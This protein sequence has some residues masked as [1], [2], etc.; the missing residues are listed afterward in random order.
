[1]QVNEVKPDKS[2]LQASV[3]TVPV[4]Q[5][6]QTRLLAC[7][8]ADQ[9]HDLA[10]AD[11]DTGPAPAPPRRADNAPS[12]RCHNCKGAAARPPGPRTAT[13]GSPT[14]TTPAGPLPSA[15][16]ACVREDGE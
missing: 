5:T 16:D 6:D 10:A 2:G 4:S 11:A 1:M 12:L 8:A 7:S 15:A 13:T 9:K 3:A 14:A